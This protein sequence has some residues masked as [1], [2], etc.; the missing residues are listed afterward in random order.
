MEDRTARKRIVAD[1]QD[2]LAA[3][4]EPI[5]DAKRLPHPKNAIKD[6]LLA[7]L[8]EA[9]I[10]EATRSLTEHF[11]SLAKWLILNEDDLRVLE[12]RGVPS[13]AG[14]FLNERE[15]VQNRD[16]ARLA[17]RVSANTIV[18]AAE[19]EHGALRFSTNRR[20]TRRCS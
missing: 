12:A 1:Y 20:S 10:L 16:Y 5:A 18:L 17:N 7:E 14:D 8:Q 9:E 19:L 3:H 4:P 6:A 2:A 13:D 11:L 15:L